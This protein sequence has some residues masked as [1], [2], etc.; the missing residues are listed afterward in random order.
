MTARSRVNTFRPSAVMA[1]DRINV[2]T[3]RV[4]ALPT[5]L[6][7]FLWRWV[8]YKISVWQMNNVDPMYPDMIDYVNDAND[9]ES[10]YGKGW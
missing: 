7:V 5:N 3:R 2:E 4:S 6:I 9:F 1:G 8:R 10:T